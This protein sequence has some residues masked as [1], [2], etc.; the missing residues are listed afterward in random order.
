V[1]VG[2]YAPERVLVT[3]GAGFI[4][5]HLVRRLIKDGHQVT[6]V[7]SLDARVHPSET[8][9]AFPD[10]VGFVRCMVDA[11]PYSVRRE[12]DRVIH[13]AAQ[14]SVADSMTDYRRYV[15]QNTYQTATFLQDMRCNPDLK[16][17]VVAS[18]MSVYGDG[19]PR[20]HEQAPCVP[21][22]VYG[23]TK[24]DQE[25]L[26]LMWGESQMRQTL[27]LRFFNVYGP[28][29]ALHNGYTGVLANFANKLLHD[30]APVIFEDGSQTRDFVYVGDVVDAVI[31]A[32]FGDVRAHGAYNIC[33]GYPTTILY[34]ATALARALGK[35][36]IEP[37]ITRKCRDGDIKHC[38]G[39][40]YRTS[41]HLGWT[42][43][44]PF[45]LGVREYAKWLLQ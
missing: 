33:T 45:D 38:T 42:S 37:H 23:L 1:A 35:G 12:Q 40:P 9:P 43:M 19:G 27:A 24:Y 7:D 2:V 20:V 22:S 13:L 17:L 14:V 30:E 18:S 21:T 31:R 8:L 29:Q 10:G 3:G 26:C 34:A 41:A 6:I 15:D 11:I 39:D 32:A 16:R 25:R 4:G 36:H 44:V 5:R 28:E